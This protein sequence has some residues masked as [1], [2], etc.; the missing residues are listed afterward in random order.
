MIRKELS[1]FKAAGT[2]DIMECPENVNIIGCKWVFRIK[3]NATSN[4]DKYKARLI[5]KGYSQVQRVNYEEIY[6]P[7]A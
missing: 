5:A 4:I 3:R 2:W 6:A 7:V 1:S